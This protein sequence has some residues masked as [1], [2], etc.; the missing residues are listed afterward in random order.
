MKGKC[1]ERRLQVQLDCGVTYPTITPARP[2][3][4]PAINTVPSRLFHSDQQLEPAGQEELQTSPANHQHRTGNIHE[5]ILY[6]RH[7]SIT[8][9]G[10]YL[11]LFLSCYYFY[12]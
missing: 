9:Q 5:H 2:L 3:D 6:A 10:W 4:V 12:G 11:T 8:L 7:C 1:K